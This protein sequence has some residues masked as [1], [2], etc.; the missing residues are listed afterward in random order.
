MFQPGT[1]A[2]GAFRRLALSVFWACVLFV[3]VGLVIVLPS[4]PATLTPYALIPVAIGVV[5]AYAVGVIDKRKTPAKRP[6]RKAVVELARSM[7]FARLFT[8]E[9]VIIAGLV[10][11]MVFWDQTPLLAALVVTVLLYTWWLRTD[12][13]L[14][15]LHRALDPVGAGQLTDAV[16]KR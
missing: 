13:F 5:G 8:G 3:V 7:I 4:A 14:G 2:F 15:A 16:I 11:G 10:V 1:S 12:N 6:D 9:V